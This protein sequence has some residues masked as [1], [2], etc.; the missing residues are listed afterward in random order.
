MRYE[1]QGEG[2]TPDWESRPRWRWSEKAIEWLKK[3][4]WAR[5]RR[6]NPNARFDINTCDRSDCMTTY[7]ITRALARALA[8]ASA[9]TI[10][11]AVLMLERLNPSY[12]DL[13]MSTTKSLSRSS[14]TGLRARS[15]RTAAATQRHSVRYSTLWIC[16]AT[17]NA[18][19]C[20]GSEDPA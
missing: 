6:W 17:R 16:K 2:N 10:P 20:V 11:A 8:R 18:P 14:I 5:R 9:S 7:L 3:I 4:S 15:G 13:A 1:N 12:P 19:I